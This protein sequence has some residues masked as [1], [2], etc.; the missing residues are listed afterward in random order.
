MLLNMLY[1]RRRQAQVSLSLSLSPPVSVSL[2]LSHSQTH[3]T[4]RAHIWPHA[5]EYFLCKKYKNTLEH[6]LVEEVEDVQV[7]SRGK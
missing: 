5:P 6:A 1:L 4:Q 7:S 2:S 3:Y